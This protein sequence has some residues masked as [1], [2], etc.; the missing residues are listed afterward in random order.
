MRAINL[1]A[2]M[3]EG[4]GDW[5][6][7]DDDALLGIVGAANIACGAHA[8]DPLIMRA[9]CAK[10]QAAGVDIG[11]HPGFDDRRGFGRRAYA[12]RA[13]EVEALVASQIGALAGAAA[14]SGARLAHVKPHGA[15]NTMAAVE[16]ALAD[17]IARAVK[18]VDARLILLG[19]AGSALVA[20]G[21][22]AGLAVAAEAFPDRA[23]AA[24]G[25]LAPRS[26]PGAVLH[27]P[28]VVAARA[29]RMLAEGGLLTPEG[30]VIPARIDTLCVHGDAPDAVAAASATRDALGAAGWTLT[31]LSALALSD[32]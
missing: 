7:G 16:R 8:G 29:R 13:E 26:Q 18:A 17:A 14:L 32:P 24:D 3:G 10:A 4:Y 15:L 22:A 1:N 27:D 25:T 6:M 2:D 11:A 5:R 31:R 30:A 23:Y 20:A 19:P 28:A 9:T 12:V 21:S